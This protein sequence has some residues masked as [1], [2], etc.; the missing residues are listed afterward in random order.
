MERIQKEKERSKLSDIK[1][2]LESQKKR[3]H[4]Q[5][6]NWMSQERTDNSGSEECGTISGMTYRGTIWSMT[7]GNLILV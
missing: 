4:D 2:L 5:L 1:A 7:S 3:C 6:N